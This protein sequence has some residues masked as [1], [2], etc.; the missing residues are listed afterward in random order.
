MSGY[1]GLLNT[2][3]HF[4]STLPTS[5]LKQGTIASLIVEFRVLHTPH[6]VSYPEDGSERGDGVWCGLQ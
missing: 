2:F 3:D 4:T 6:G 1:Q 5:R